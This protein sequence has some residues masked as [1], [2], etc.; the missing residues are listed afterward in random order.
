MQSTR[1]AGSVRDEL[2]HHFLDA[3][4]ANVGVGRVDRVEEAHPLVV[5]QHGP[6]LLLV[7]R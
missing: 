5:V 6:R 7:D 4:V 2:V 3:L 1:R